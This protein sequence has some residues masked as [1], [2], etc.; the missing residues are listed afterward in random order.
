M[1]TLD[2]FTPNIIVPDRN[3]D[4]WHALEA[5]EILE[6]LA[7]PA[8]TGLTT[9]EASQRLEQYGPNQLREAPPVT[10]WQMLWQ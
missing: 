3:R 5:E 2:K 8:D 4:S 7:T 1:A 6:Q 10:F 9:E